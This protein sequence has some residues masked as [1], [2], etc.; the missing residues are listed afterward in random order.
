MSMKAWENLSL[1]LLGHVPVMRYLCLGF[2]LGRRQRK[3]EGDRT[4][5]GGK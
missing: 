3:D 4:E 5:G 2:F 1:L